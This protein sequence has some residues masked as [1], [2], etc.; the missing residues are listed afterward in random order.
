MLVASRSVSLR[1]SH[2]WIHSNFLLSPPT[3]LKVASARKTLCVLMCKTLLGQ[4]EEHSE[5]PAPAISS[6]TA[7]MGAPTTISSTTGGAHGTGIGT[8][9]VAIARTVALEGTKGRKR[10]YPWLAVLAAYI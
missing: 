9:G 10:K 7:D 6:A 5:L 1:A 8:N 3:D 4:R 2:D